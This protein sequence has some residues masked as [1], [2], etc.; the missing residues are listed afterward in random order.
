VT[1]STIVRGTD[2]AIIGDGVIGLS[3]A[4]ELANAGAT[5]CIIG[6]HR[7]G[8]AS[9]AAAG[10][11][12]PTV[13]HIPSGAQ[14][15]FMAS[16]GRY[17]AFVEALRE[18]EPGL[19]ILYG[20]IEVSSPASGH[21]HAASSERLT[22]EDLSRLEPSLSAP[23]GGLFHAHDGAIDN[24]RLMLA[25][26]RAVSGQPRVRIIADNP[27]VAVGVTAD[28]ASVDLSDGTR[29]E[30]A[31]VVIA[32]GAWSP[33]L[34]GLPRPLPVTPLKGQMLALGGGN[35]IRHAVMGGD[36]YL[37]PREHET[38]IGATSEL[39]GF[40]TTT[41]P[42]AIE[43]L[44]AAAVSLCPALA[45]APTRRAWAGIRPATPDMLPII[46]RDPDA[47][48]LLYA[49]G[50]SKNGILLAPATAR[51]VT[52]LARETQPESDLSAFSISRFS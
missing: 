17:S 24:V 11:L 41:N 43:G 8:A 14:P 50:H 51:A 47:P 9:S 49:C 39:A 12:A 10:L 52:A 25:L 45:T 28:L 32:A 33:A 6:N 42:R 44:R 46:G 18:F 35:A 38:V 23:W 48:R 15:F 40:D 31:H 5:C 1:S 22:S 7:D 20:L 3:T 2:V 13:G 4:L 19:S 16:L 37:V 21:S 34:R 36:V 30:A 27:A 29:A 26:R